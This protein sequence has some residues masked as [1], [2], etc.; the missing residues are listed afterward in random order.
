MPELPEVETLRRELEPKLIGACITDVVV[1]DPRVVGTP[2]APLFVART[3][4]QEVQRVTRRAK[5][6]LLGLSS[7][8]TLA[9]HRGMAG[10]LLLRPPG[11]GEDRHVRVCFVLDDG[12]E[13]R[14]C[15][16][17]V[18]GRLLLLSRHEVQRLDEHLGPEP[19]AEDFTE[20]SLHTLLAGH[21]GRIKP[22]LMDQHRLAGLGNIYTD[23]ALFLAG[24]HPE[25]K[26]DSVTAEEVGRL[27]RAIREV[28]LQGIVNRGTTLRDHLDSGGQPGANQRAL[29]VFGR[30]GQ[31]CTRCGTTIE[32]TRVN[33]RG[34]YYCPG[35]Q[36]G[37]TIR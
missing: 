4:G 35:C 19:L 31:P 24:I 34:T 30:D 18:F 37:L 26:A 27:Y 2:P 12:R 10:N 6:L 21:R 17:R 3:I 28:L 11:S 29:M 20:A 15:D 23:E 9:V 1:K 32:K 25:R 5:Y 22:L 33:G 8:D 16:S 13:L 7:G 14:F 36:A